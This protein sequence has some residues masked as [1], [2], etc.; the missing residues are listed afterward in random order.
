MKTSPRPLEVEPLTVTR[1]QAAEAAALMKA[2]SN[3][4]RLMILCVLSEGEMPVGELNQR[5]PLSQSGL[6][7]QLAILRREGLVTARREAQSVRYA[8]APTNA[9]RVIELLHDMYC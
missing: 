2:L 3:P 8:L 9:L 6:S 4:N 7:Q 5:V 1:R